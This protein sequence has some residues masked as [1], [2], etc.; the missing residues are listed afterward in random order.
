MRYRV[1]RHVT[2]DDMEADEVTIHESGAVSFD[3]IIDETPL[4]R[5]RA[6]VS[7]YAA[8]QWCKVESV[9]DPEKISS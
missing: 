7:A 1:I 9:S 8:G 4:S 5:R 6:L 3:K 2:A